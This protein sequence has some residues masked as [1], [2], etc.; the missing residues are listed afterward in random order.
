MAA[1]IKV[2]LVPGGGRRGV[3][4]IGIGKDGRAVL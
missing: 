2:V 3:Y 4:G 1:F